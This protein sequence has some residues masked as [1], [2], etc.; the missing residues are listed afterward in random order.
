MPK[1]H[2]QQALFDFF[3]RLKHTPISPKRAPVVPEVREV[4]EEKVEVAPSTGRGRD[5]VLE[6]QART[7][8]DDLGIH[9][10]AIRVQVI[11]NAR[12]RSTAGYAKWPA[13]RVELNPKLM[14]M[15]GEVERTLKH[16]L[17]HLI[18]YSRAAGKRIDAH[19]PEWRKA[20]A[21]LGIPDESARHSLPLPRSQQKRK[22]AYQCPSCQQVV[23]RVKRFRRHVACLACCQKYNRGQFDARFAFKLLPSVPES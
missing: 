4:I 20:C 1:P 15:E 8:L 2:T 21:D 6:A 18:A 10:G 5:H 7:W 19:G 3:A 16:E 13:W 14:P 23:Q 9:E 17:A 22:F 12:L 11:W